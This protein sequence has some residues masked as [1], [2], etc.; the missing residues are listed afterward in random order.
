MARE[1]DPGSHIAPGA[2][3]ATG[4]QVSVRRAVP[5]RG[6]AGDPG[7]ALAPGGRPGRPEEPSGPGGSEAGERGP[8]NASGETESSGSGAPT[9]PEARTPA[10]QTAGADPVR[11]A[12]APAPAASSAPSAPAASS[13]AVAEGDTATAAAR[14]SSASSE[15]AAVASSSAPA[16]GSGGADGAT[17]VAAGPGGGPGARTDEDP[18][19]SR[20]KKP[21][22]AAAAIAGAVLISVPFLVAGQDD[23]RKAEKE[24][25][26]NA[27]GTVLDAA[28]PPAPETYTSETP[29]P[30]PTPS[31]KKK[32]EKKK[33]PVK[34]SAPQP[35]KPVVVT[36]T[37]T[38]TPTPSPSKQ[39]QK[40][41]TSTKAPAGT[42]AAALEH[43]AK[44][45]PQGRHICY[46]AFVAGQGWQVPVCDGTMT[47]TTGQGKKITAL[48]ISVWNVEGS[49]ANA[50]LHDAGAK[51][52]NAKWAPSWTP[53][54]ANG[55]NVYIGSS[56]AGAPFMTG[57][58]M[59][60][61]KGNV[62]HTAK[63]RNG[64]WG[65]QYCKSSRPDYMFVGTTD[66]GNWFEAVKLTV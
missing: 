59:N 39:Q 19:G 37:P 21:M 8:V 33:E 23:D 43:L 22:L 35:L 45:D 64:G 3:G 12:G 62:C 10:P 47:G 48:N 52:G 7:D 30:S 4:S 20:P 1:Q 42:A 58:A 6:A 65:P 61:G 49:S 60:V 11:G 55:K 18:P 32:E 44:S 16:P 29:K 26:Q 40:K 24:Q 57:F 46:R 9:A 51:S 54:I 5:M 56:K 31:R 25:T 17:A 2:A 41:K 50:L 66:N 13:A 27:A 53:V 15:P 38:P 28:R 14:P 36:P 63:M 34:P